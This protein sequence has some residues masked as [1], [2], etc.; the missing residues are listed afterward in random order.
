MEHEVASPGMQQGGH[1]QLHTGFLPES[2]QGIPRCVE[3]GSISRLLM[4]EDEL[5]QHFRNCEHDVE[6]S[7]RQKFFLAGKKP[8]FPLRILTSWTVTVPATVIE[9]VLLT[10]FRTYGYVAT[11][12]RCTTIA[13][14]LNRG[15]TIPRGPSRTEP[16]KGL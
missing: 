9:S 11:Q 14:V 8:G 6:V 3:Q 10:A 15:R 4:A 1:P 5:V 13:D 2:I 16:D 12:S 7:L